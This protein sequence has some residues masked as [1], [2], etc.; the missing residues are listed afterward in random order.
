[1]TGERMDKGVESVWD[2][3]V[4]NE[5]EMADCQFTIN[6]TTLVCDQT[7]L[8]APLKLRCATA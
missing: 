8:Q 7:S 4:R 3:A 5:G 1:M 2:L 6:R